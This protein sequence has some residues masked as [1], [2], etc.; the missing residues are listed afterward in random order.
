LTY[1]LKKAKEAAG[2]RR[3]KDRG[4]RWKEHYGEK[5]LP[6]KE[7][8]DEIVG[9]GVYHRWEGHDYTTF[10]DYFVVVGPSQERYGKK[11]F[12]AGIKK[13]PPKWKRKKVYAPDGEYFSN[14]ASAL[15]HASKKWGIPYPKNQHNYSTADLENVEIP[16]HIKG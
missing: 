1:N 5:S 9:P 7:R 15:S 6:L 3:I 16:R 14:I 11:S 2:P 10:S 8:L 13:L 4:I 12:F